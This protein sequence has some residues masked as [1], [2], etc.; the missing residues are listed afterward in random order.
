[1]M[2]GKYFFHITSVSGGVVATTT[3]GVFGFGLACFANRIGFET[4]GKSFP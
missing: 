2:K 1:M 3:T 4:E